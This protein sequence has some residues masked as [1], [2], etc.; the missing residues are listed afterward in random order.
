[1]LITGFSGFLNALQQVTIASG[2]TVSAF[3]KTGG[4]SLVG[5]KVPAA[6]TGVALTFQMCDTEGGTYVP[7][8]NAL[9]PVSYTVAPGRYVAI[10][11]KDFYGI[12]F[13]KIVSGTAEGATRT[14][15]CSL[16]G[17]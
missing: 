9:G 7:V 10:D 13:L 6:F 3:I 5:I 2:Q 17:L 14:L 12:A 4:F 15:V 11:P 8:Y 1:M 16:K